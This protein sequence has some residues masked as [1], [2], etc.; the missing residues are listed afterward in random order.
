MSAVV[1]L[2]TARKDLVST[3]RET[4][5]SKATCAQDKIYGLYG[6]TRDAKS[7]DLAVNYQKPP[8]NIYTDLGRRLLLRNGREALSYGLP[9][10]EDELEDAGVPSWL[11]FYGF[12][13]YP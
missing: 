6:V 2:R 4:K 5:R 7:L 13:V 8:P 1:G 10:A 12:L 3:L 9:V 11:T